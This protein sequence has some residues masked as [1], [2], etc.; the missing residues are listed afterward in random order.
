MSIFGKLFKKRSLSPEKQSEVLFDMG[1]MFIS[2]GDW[3]SAFEPIKKASDLGHR[4]A[5]GQLAMMYVFGNGCGK[6]EKTGLKLL[7]FSAEQGNLF[8]CYAF[9]VLYDN[10]I[11]GISAEEAE[12]MC[13]LAAQAGLP[14]AAARME[15]G[16]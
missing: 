5:M 3:E 4:G 6:D 13:A 10:G 12:N 15:Q 14:E 16:F 8:S 9:S 11:G 7:R 2:D 1:M